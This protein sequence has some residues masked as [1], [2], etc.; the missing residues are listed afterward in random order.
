MKMDKAERKC[1]I[2][3]VVVGAEIE[4]YLMD[5]R[6][7][8]YSPKSIEVYRRALFDLDAYLA[9]TGLRR[10]EDVTEDILAG[11]RLSLLDRGFKPAS[12]AVY[13]RAVR[14]LFLRLEE[15]RCI[16]INP[17][18]GLLI[19]KAGTPLQ[20]VPGE[21][22]VQALLDAPDTT[23]AC[24]LRDR[25]ILETAYA[26]GARRAEL[27]GMSLDNVDLPSRTLR[28]MGK[29][30]R[31]RIVP[32]GLFAATW[33]ARYI[34]DIRPQFPACD[35]N[36]LWLGRSG[37]I[38]PEGIGYIFI[39]HSQAAGIRPPLRP[40]AIRRACATHM[41]GHG[42]SPVEIQTLLG[43]SCLKH[44]SQYLAVSITEMKQSHA[45]SRLGA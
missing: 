14:R 26:T 1:S 18:A 8:R 31:E 24:G 11:Y 45:Q 42:A 34:T 7:R 39:R 16:F 35:S 30:S 12:M 38:K 13:F 17:A 27:S 40:H 25:A 21:P 29:G 41:L 19:R 6:S 22:Q 5:L 33:L 3:A 23:T 20:P 4:V 15:Q 32:L 9:G 43:H 36:H 28:L 44:L 2:C 10:A 37:P